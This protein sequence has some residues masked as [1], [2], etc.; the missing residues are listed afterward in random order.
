MIKKVGLGIVVLSECW[1]RDKMNQ[2]QFRTF[3]PGRLKD[4]I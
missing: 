3:V 1:E 4:A 2:E